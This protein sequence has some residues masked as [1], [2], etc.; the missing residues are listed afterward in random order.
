MSKRK[1][2]E[3]PCAY[4]ACD[5]VAKGRRYCHGCAH[6]VYAEN[7]PEREIFRNLRF[8][9][10]R[11]KIKFTLTFSWFMTW[12]QGEGKGYLEGRGRCKNDL[13]IDR[14]I[15]RL[16]YSEGNLQVLTR[17]A[18]TAKAFVDNRKYGHSWSVSGWDE[19]KDGPRPF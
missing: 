15:P 5:K 4:P 3:K 1:L 19:L 2:L 10:S 13:T 12:L 8:N 7:N 9:A 6:K 11:R 16:G 17:A 18:N 14:K